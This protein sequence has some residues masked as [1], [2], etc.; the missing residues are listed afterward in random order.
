MVL[1][2]TKMHGCGNDYVYFDCME[3]EFENPQHYAKVLSNRRYGI[4]SDGIILICKSKVA[5]AKMRMFNN[6]G[7]EGKMCGNGIR[8]VFKFLK[9]NGYVK[10]DTATIETLSGIKK[11]SLIK[12]EPND[13]IKVDMGKAE[14]ESDKIP[15]NIN[16]KKVLNYEVRYK[17]ETLKI[18]A[19]SMGN[20][21]CVIFKDD[22]ENIDLD[23]IGEYFQANG[24]FPQ[25]VNVEFIKVID[26]NNIEMRVYERGSKETLACGTGACAA[27]V[28]AYEN[29]Y[30]DREVN[31]KL[32]GGTLKVIYTDNEVYLIGEAVTVYKGRIELKG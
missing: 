29:G 30:C 20:P 5:D 8:C 22:I 3:K 4:G 1:E 11:L 10:D 12:N 23:G 17:D 7:S 16:S 31:V 24:L 13:M 26:K 9:D 6:D 25:G 15:M 27:A 32:K 2:F 18:T 28:A 21:H 14:F 19:L